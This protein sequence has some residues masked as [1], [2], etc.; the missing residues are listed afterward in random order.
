MRVKDKDTKKLD[1]EIGR[2][3][4]KVANGIEIS[5]L[6]IPQ[7]FREIHADVANGK[8][9]EEACKEAAGRHRLN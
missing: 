1:A 6:K 3:S 2:V 7:I 8:T 4:P 5:L 9:V